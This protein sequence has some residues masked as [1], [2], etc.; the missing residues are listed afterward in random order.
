SRLEYPIESSQVSRVEVVVTAERGEGYRATFVLHESDRA[1][2]SRSL[3]ALACEQAVQALA[4]AAALALDARAREELEPTR[5]SSAA[6]APEPEQGAGAAMPGAQPVQPVDTADQGPGEPRAAEAAAPEEA[7]SAA[8]KR[9]ADPATASDPVR[10]V[11][12]RPAL[13]ASAVLGYWVEVGGFVAT[14]YAPGTSVG[15]RLGFSLSLDAMELGAQL[16]YAVESTAAEG[17]QRARFSAF[18]GRIL[19]CYR[20]DL[21]TT[22]F[23][24][25]C[26][27]AEY[28]A[29]FSEGVEGAGVSD[30]HSDST[31]FWALGLS[32]G[33]GARLSPRLHLLADLGFTFPLTRHRFKFTNADEYLHSYP[34]VALRAG[35]GVGYG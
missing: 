28:A 30:I 33:F 26:L 23:G 4:L 17:V 9:P 5:G 35:L 7:A 10:D 19:P 2:V 31:P 14:G 27:Q 16:F 15:P 24:R 1:P 21:S 22:N 8:R 13:P 12:A 20:L 6:G 32:V 3:Q 18:G 29:I 11:E 25:G 34:R